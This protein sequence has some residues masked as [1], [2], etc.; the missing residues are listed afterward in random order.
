M[1]NKKILFGALAVI[2][3]AAIIGYNYIYQDHRDIQSE[4]P[5]FTI[6]A[7]DFIKDFQENETEATTKY[8][9]KTVQ[10]EGTLSSVDGNTIVVE[11][12]IFFALSENE[13]PPSLDQVD[14]VIQVKA[15]CIGYDN[16]LEEVKLDQAS[17]Q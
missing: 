5:A 2:I 9:N 3:L 4:K 14:N 1:K 10:I 12:V 8:L 17:V 13:T 11:N 7:T 16:L 15:R 6:K